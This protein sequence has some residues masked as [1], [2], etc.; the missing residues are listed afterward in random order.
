MTRFLYFFFIVSCCLS[1][2]PYALAE[3]QATESLLARKARDIIKKNDFGDHRRL[4]T[5][6]HNPP[7]L[8]Y[9][10]LLPPEFRN[11]VLPRLTSHQ[12]LLDAGAGEM[13]AMEE[14]IESHPRGA[15]VVAYSHKLIRT[16]PPHP[17]LLPLSGQFLENIDLG[18]VGP[19]DVIIDVYGV[20]AYTSDPLLIVKK[21]L[22]A[23][24]VGGLAYIIVGVD[25]SFK[26]LESEVASMPLENFIADQIRSVGH[27]ASIIETPVIFPHKGRRI[28]A[29]TSFTL[30]IEKKHNRSPLWPRLHLAEMEETARP[31]LMTFFD[32]PAKEPSLCQ[33][34]LSFF[35]KSNR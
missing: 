15:H 12:T 23:L 3:Q 14:Y 11:H 7:H 24:K 1:G 22:N 19:F 4:F 34:I 13:H 2:P 33:K 35:G 31:P 28:K 10:G 29:K 9:T 6:D 20:Y 16:L 27:E 26:T 8:A 21:Y 17:R 25:E 30:K 32:E 18:Q 5:D